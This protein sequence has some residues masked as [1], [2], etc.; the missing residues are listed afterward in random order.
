MLLEVCIHDEY[1]DMESVSST[2]MWFQVARLLWQMSLPDEP[3]C[4]LLLGILN[5]RETLITLNYGSSLVSYAEK[6]ETTAERELVRE[7]SRNHFTLG[8]IR[9]HTRPCEPECS[10]GL[11]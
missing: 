8:F 5:M 2:F 1:V 10:S 3:S 7:T 9:K 6:Q 11:T 4:Q